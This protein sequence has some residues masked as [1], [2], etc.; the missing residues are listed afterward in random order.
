L[1][2]PIGIAQ[3]TGEITRQGGLQGW[4]LVAIL[5]SINLAILNILPIPMLDGGHLLFFLIEAMRG[6]PL[7][8]RQ[9]E[10]AQQMGLMLL[11]FVMVY[12]F[13]NDLAR[14]FGS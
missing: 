2:G 8:A 1:S 9:R 12:A 4:V 11:L 14:I 10:R 3:I 6:R 5:L 7:E 13:Y